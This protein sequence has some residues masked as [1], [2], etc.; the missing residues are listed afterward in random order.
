MTFIERLQE[1]MR[2]FAFIIDH[3]Q[4]VTSVEL[5][6]SFAEA[7]KPYSKRVRDGEYTITDQELFKVNCK[8]M[9]N[10]I[11]VFF[12]HILE[13]HFK[14]M[15]N[16]KSFSQSH[17]YRMLMIKIDLNFYATSE[18][19]K[20]ATSINKGFKFI[21]IFTHKETQ[22]SA[23]KRV[24]DIQRYGYEK[25]LESQGYMQFSPDFIQELAQ[26]KTG[27]SLTVDEVHQL[28]KNNMLIFNMDGDE[29][30]FIKSYFIKHKNFIYRINIINNRIKENYLPDFQIYNMGND[31]VIEEFGIDVSEEGF[32]ILRMM[33]Y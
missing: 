21:D 6:S 29:H 27:E 2:A 3:H 5:D 24:G 4:Q 30:D 26:Y 8:D 17:D 14:Y 9:V 31:E 7:L 18:R 16:H 32:E 25:V 13:D 10:N 23:L 1:E 28:Y 15:Q 22:L 33:H 19:C 12:D 11:P 20:Y